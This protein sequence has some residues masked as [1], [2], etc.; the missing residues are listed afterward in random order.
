MA[1]FPNSKILY[2]GNRFHV[3]LL[4]L[5]F[6]NPATRAAELTPFVLMELKK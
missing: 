2:K 3:T 1:D 5:Q 4:T 6:L